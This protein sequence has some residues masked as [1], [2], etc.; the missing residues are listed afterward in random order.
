MNGRYTV[1]LSHSRRDALTV[2]VRATSEADAGIVARLRA[3]ELNPG[4]ALDD[5]TATSVSA[6]SELTRE[7]LRDARAVNASYRLEELLAIGKAVVLDL[8]DGADA[9]YAR[10]YWLRRELGYVVAE[11]GV[12]LPNHAELKAVTAEYEAL[13]S[14]DVE[15]AEPTARNAPTRAEREAWAFVSSAG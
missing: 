15:D 13:V 14:D 6:E 5:W 4:D 12:G 8:R 1:E 10:V 2:T 3:A 9:P 11:L 7:P